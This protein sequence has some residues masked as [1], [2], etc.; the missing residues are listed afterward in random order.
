MLQKYLRLSQ[1]EPRMRVTLASLLIAIVALLIPY[2]PLRSGAPPKV[3]LPHSEVP[4]PLAQGESLVDERKSKLREPFPTAIPSPQHR[5]MP[6]STPV[7][8]LA[9]DEQPA[10]PAENSEIGELS[11]GGNVPVD[12]LDDLD[13]LLDNAD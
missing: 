3:S 1:I 7:E 6:A 12:S 8:E 5:E 9:A 11:P 4:H 13:A 10:E 2:I